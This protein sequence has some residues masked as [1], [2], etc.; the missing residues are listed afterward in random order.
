MAINLDF[1]QGVLSYVSLA[2]LGS[3]GLSGLFALCAK[4]SSSKAHELDAVRQ[5]DSLAGAHAALYL[6]ASALPDVR[7]SSTADLKKLAGLVPLLVAVTGR[8]CS[9]LPLQCE[10]TSDKAVIREV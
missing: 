3:L 2:G 10:M 1:N 6:V 9:K 4:A 5:L 7:P 8:V